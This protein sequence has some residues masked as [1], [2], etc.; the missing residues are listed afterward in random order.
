MVQYSITPRWVRKLDNDEL[1][2]LRARRDVA[3][4]DALRCHACQPPGATPPPGVQREARERLERRAATVLEATMAGRAPERAA[5]SGNGRATARSPARAAGAPAA[6]ARVPRPPHAPHRRLRTPRL[7]RPPRPSSAYEPSSMAT[8]TISSSCPARAGSA[9]RGLTL[10]GGRRRRRI[11]LPTGQACRRCAAAAELTAYAPA[12]SADRRCPSLAEPQRPARLY[13]R[14]P[15]F[16]QRPLPRDG[17]DPATSARRCTRAG[18]EPAEAEL[19][20]VGTGSCARRLTELI[21]APPYPVAPHELRLRP[22]APG[23]R[24]PAYAHIWACEAEQRGEFLRPKREQDMLRAYLDRLLDPAWPA[25][26]GDILATCASARRHHARRRRRREALHHALPGR[27]GRRDQP[28]ALETLAD[29][30]SARAPTDAAGCP[31]KP[32]RLAAFVVADRLLQRA[33][34]QRLTYERGHRRAHPSHSGSGSRPDLS[35]EAV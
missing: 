30:R 16:G 10:E 20:E 8:T 19:V 12:V 29:A 22:G 33:P 21:E 6:R 23:R 17:A 11:L 28:D 27:P 34:R 18:I 35:P 7:S 24:A 32:D 4:E 15:R 3:E 13:R 25:L 26:Y 2:P 14:D 31:A 9:R 1:A 5:P